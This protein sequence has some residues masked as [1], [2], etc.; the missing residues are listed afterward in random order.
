MR[1]SIFQPIQTG[2]RKLPDTWGSTGRILRRRVSSPSSG[3]SNGRKQ[4]TLQLSRRSSP[5]TRRTL[6]PSNSLH[7]PLSVLRSLQ[8]RDQPGANGDDVCVHSEDIQKASRWRKF[9]SSVPALEAI[10]EAAHLDYQRDRRLVRRAKWRSRASRRQRI[11]PD[12][13]QSYGCRARNPDWAN[14]T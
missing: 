6:K 13:P 10:N 7:T 9:T 2:S 11:E 1:R 3:D 12:R 5:I 8:R 14:G 4:P